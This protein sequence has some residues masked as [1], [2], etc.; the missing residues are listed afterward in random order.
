PGHE[1][2]K[3]DWRPVGLTKKL[4]TGGS[5]KTDRPQTDPGCARDDMGRPIILRLK[6]RRDDRVTAAGTAALRLAQTRL[7]IISAWSAYASS[8]TLLPAPRTGSFSPPDQ[9]DPPSP[10]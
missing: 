3:Q 2:E 8:P 7:S 1:G 9:S 6:R 10:A 5:E 4:S